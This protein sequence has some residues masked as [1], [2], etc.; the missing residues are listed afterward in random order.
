MSLAM[1]WERAGALAL[2]QHTK[3]AQIC[4]SIRQF[5]NSDITTMVE[6]RVRTPLSVR[7]LDKHSYVEAIGT[8]RPIPRYGA[9]TCQVEAWCRLISF[10]RRFPT[11][12]TLQANQAGL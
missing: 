10:L 9:I 4:R 1:Y 2:P 7:R 12:Y 11:R 6:Q 5:T 3:L 8:A